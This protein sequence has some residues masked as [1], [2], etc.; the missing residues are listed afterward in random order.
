MFAQRIEICGGTVTKVDAHTVGPGCDIWFKLLDVSVT[1]KGG[2]VDR[3]LIAAG[4][5]FLAAI[6]SNSSSQVS[7][8]SLGGT[9]KWFKSSFEREKGVDLVAVT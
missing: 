6:L 1:F 5:V 3:R 4:E 2:E 7:S 8:I 9:Q